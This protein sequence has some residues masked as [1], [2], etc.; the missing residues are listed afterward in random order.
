MEKISKLKK[1]FNLLL[2]FGIPCSYAEISPE[3]ITIEKLKRAH[4]HRIYLTDLAL[5]HVIDG[6]I[7]IL[8]GADN[9][10]YLGLI[11]TGMMGLTAL[12][13]DRSEMLVATTYYS[14]G[15][16]GEKSEYLE[17]YDTNDL[18][19][20]MEIK[21]PPRHAQALPYVGT[22]RSSIDDRYV[23]IQN[24]TPATSISIIDKKEKK[25]VHEVMTPGCWIILP[26]AS[27][28]K[29]FSTM[30][31]DGT[32]LTVT[33]NSEGVPTSQERSDKLFDAD[34]DPLFVQAENIKDV[35]FF[36]SF[37]GDVYE[38]DLSGPTAS[39]NSKWSLLEDDDLTEK[40]RPSGYQLL[41]ISKTSNRMYVAMHKNGREGS[42]KFPGDEI[43]SY[44]IKSQSRIGRSPGNNT[45]AMTLT[46]EQTPHLYAYDGINLQIHKYETTPNL[47]H[48][49]MSDLIG[50]FA[51]LIQTH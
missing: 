51:G 46:K 7:H 43:W 32:F 13:N 16:R 38:I 19:L 28:D 21:I 20:K 2:I 29:K 45:I 44:D 23:Y 34:K 17:A 15:T 27:N 22:M 10:K 30:C 37:L 40:W 4:P 48:V 24:A 26:S 8:D 6:R 33:H 41:A 11:G 18:S 36:V 12:S 39:L 35:F 50:E 3:T 25:F 49:D 31:G 9:F 1:I 47:K 5:N 42:H 14:K